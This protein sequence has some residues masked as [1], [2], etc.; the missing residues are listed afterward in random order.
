ML[1]PGGT[2]T[3]RSVPAWSAGTSVRRETSTSSPTRGCWGASASM[4]RY[5]AAAAGTTA[6]PTA[7]PAARKTR[8]TILLRRPPASR[9][10]PLRRPYLRHE[11]LLVVGRIAAVVVRRDRGRV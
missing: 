8:L 2:A 7:R 6:S 11:L 4:I 10:A 9:S 5:F 3:S 1:I